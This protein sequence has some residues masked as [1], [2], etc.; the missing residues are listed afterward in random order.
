MIVPAVTRTV[1][2]RDLVEEFIAAVK[3][4]PKCEQVR[5]A[6]LALT[7]ALQALTTVCAVFCPAFTDSTH[8]S[9]LNPAM[10]SLSQ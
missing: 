1:A 4:L 7:T 8:V 2:D 10:K 5:L 6:P 3:R 9:S